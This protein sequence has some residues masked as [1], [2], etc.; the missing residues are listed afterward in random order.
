[1]AWEAELDELERRLAFAEGLGGPEGI[2]RQ[3]RYGK[4]TVRE[5]LSLLAD[6]GTF[7]ASG[8]FR[9]H[10]SYDA[11]GNLEHVVPSGRIEGVCRVDGRKVFVTAGDFTVR[12]GSAES[13]HGSLGVE[14]SASERALEWRLPY[15]RLLDSAGGS[16]RGFETLGRT[17][18]P[19]GNSFTQFD[20]KL[21]NAVP[22]VSAVLGAAAGIAALQ[23]CL[24]H[25]NVMVRSISQVFPG[26]PPVV[27][28]ALGH[29]VTKEELGG[30]DIHV[31]DSGVVDNL[32]DDEE[33]AFRQI[34]AF[35][36]YLPSSVDESAPRGEAGVDPA[37]PA[38]E[39]RDVVPED[40]RRPFTVR[41]LI[42]AVVDRG[43]FFEVAPLYGR[44]RVTGLARIDGYPVGVMA[45]DPL[46]NGGA[47]DV[48]AGRKALRLIQLCDTFHLPLVD[49]ADEP[50]LMVGVRA[51]K[52]GIERAGA[53]L[54][55]GIVNS[56]MPWITFV[57]RRLYGVGGQAHHRPSGMY[58]RYAWPSANWGSMHIA[59]GTS[60]AYRREI[61][62]APDP[63]AR[64]AEI[65]ARLRRLSSPFRAAEVT[66]QDIIDPADTRALLVEFVH[67]AQRVLAR[68]LGTPP[69]PYVP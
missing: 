55:C 12:G 58:R 33:D 37:R 5:R 6:P 51:E 66:G 27:K 1:M 61:E 67:E 62:A 31:R 24:A 60:A 47:T 64:R 22:V 2:E 43:S 41:R 39:L 54:I 15:V 19:D 7:Q 56:R 42:E 13:A 45:N 52:E 8:A 69:F 21:L 3:H 63:E 20:V 32:A 36:S 26:G 44:S 17:Y 46:R 28:A 59:G 49:L 34:R 30:P 35:L 23:T 38:S 10:A 4:L 9:G 16:V 50:G 29:D 18:L 25:W 57:I 14:L 11:D 65:E 40:P 53:Q 68:Q 48:A